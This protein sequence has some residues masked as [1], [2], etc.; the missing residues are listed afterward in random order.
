MTD[1]ETAPAGLAGTLGQYLQNVRLARNF[2]LRQV[3]GLTN[4]AVSNAYLSQIESGKVAQ[5]SPNILHALANAYSVS[6]EQ[7]M[8]M[9]GFFPGNDQDRKPDP[10]YA[11]LADLNLT[12]SEQQDLIDYLHFRRAQEKKRAA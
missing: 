6:Y 10:T 7:L 8:E 5:P 12:P 3:E 4:K 2:S 11:V 9:A 1:T